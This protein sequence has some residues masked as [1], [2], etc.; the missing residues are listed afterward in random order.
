LGSV[1]EGVGEVRREILD[2]RLEFWDLVLGSWNFDEILALV[3][4]AEIN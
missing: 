3:C 1:G 2:L 4:A